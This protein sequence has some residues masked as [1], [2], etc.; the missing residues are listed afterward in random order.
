MNGTQQTQVDTISFNVPI[1]EP[2]SSVNAYIQV[3]LE[4]I[5]FDRTASMYILLI[6]FLQMRAIAIFD[7]ST[8]TRTG[9]WSLPEIVT[10]TITPPPSDIA[11]VSEQVSFTVQRT[12]SGELELFVGLEVEWTTSNITNSN[13]QQ[14][15][16]QTDNTMFRVAI[17]SR[18]IDTFGE[19][20]GDTTVQS[21]EVG[22]YLIF[23]CL[24][25]SKN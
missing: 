12:T 13:V 18:P 6:T 15:K 21:F 11:I 4:S 8:I 5:V 9:N 7:G 23:K 14:R 3:Q 10:L 20:P 16:R 25:L 2:G 17:G 24:S 19:V 1:P 22:D